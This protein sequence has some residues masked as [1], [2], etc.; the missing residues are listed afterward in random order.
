[1]NTRHFA[2]FVWLRS[3]IR[4]NQLRRGGIANQIILAL[5]VGMAVMA[6]VG[7]LVGGFFA[8][9]IAM[10]KADAAARLLVWDGVV[11]AFLFMWMIGLL[12]DIQRSDPLTLDRF[13]HLPVSPSGVFVI[14]YLS[15]LSSM[16]LLLFVAAAGGLLVGQL[17]AVGPVMLLG[18]V[19]L[20]A[21]VFAVTA[22]TYQ[23]QGWLAVLMSNPRR[24]RTIVVFVTFGVILVAQ[25]PN[26]I[27]ILRPWKTTTPPSV[28]LPPP[29]P[30]ST[31]P[32]ETPP[33]RPLAPPYAEIKKEH[34]R[35]TWEQVSDTAWL[36]NAVIPPGWLPN[37]LASLS[38]GGVLSTLLG[39]LGFVAVG[40]G[41]LYRAYRTTVK[42]HTGQF[43]TGGSA[44]APKQVAPLPIDKPTMVEWQLPRVSEHAAAVAVS[45]LRGLLRAPETKMLM[46]V[47]VILAVVLGGLLIAFAKDI[48]QPVR[49]LIAIGLS[50]M[51]LLTG[52]QVAGN[53]FGY[54]RAGFRAFVLAPLSQRDLLLGKNLALAPILLGI[55]VVLA[56]LVGIVLPMRPD[57]YPMVIAQLV[58]L[59]LL[60][61]LMMNFLSIVA[62]MP[63]AAGAMQ[64]TNVKLAPVLW[65]FGFMM[66]YPFGVGLVLLPLGIEVL[67]QEITQ[68]PWLPIGVVLSFGLLTAVTVV[69]RRSLT[70][71]GEWLT[72]RE[73]DIL[74]V[75]TSKVE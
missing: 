54:D 16:T 46:L 61:C 10:P 51:V 53:Q 57:H 20:A 34:D 9:L 44:K 25:T 52:V 68:I 47:P 30:I 50:A 64:P 70:A 26:L 31:K 33:T 18:F 73:K 22:L 12:T 49:P 63:L 5:L 43:A 67:T 42:Y 62:P 40:G 17:F 19:L 11:V 21:F 24:R 45:S 66:V 74:L 3:R 1:M 48:P 65:Q 56:M 23:F 38:E 4:V 27:N 7:L 41:C 15:S 8:G 13:L 69:Y 60:Y 29:E 55:G 6:A 58:S 14:N 59:Y 28:V 2:T 36:L 71:Q 39:T 37:G 75:V 72:R 32:G 35:K